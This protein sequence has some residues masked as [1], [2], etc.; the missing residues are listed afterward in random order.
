[1]PEQESITRVWA[2]DIGP[3]LAVTLG[4]FLMTGYSLFV[5]DDSSEGIKMAFMSL[6]GTA[7]GYW[8]GSSYGSNRKTTAMVK[9]LN[10]T[11]ND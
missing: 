11:G 1:M 8:I 5:S 4:I 10:D 2:T 6:T 9:E 3:K 7:A